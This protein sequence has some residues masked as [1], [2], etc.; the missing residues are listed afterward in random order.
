[1]LAASAGLKKAVLE[2]KKTHCLSNGFFLIKDSGVMQ[3]RPLHGHIVLDLFIQ[4]FSLNL[5]DFAIHHSNDIAH[6]FNFIGVINR[7]VFFL[8]FLRQYV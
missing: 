7:Q 4:V 2:S 8:I 6:V 1:M 5:A 3:M